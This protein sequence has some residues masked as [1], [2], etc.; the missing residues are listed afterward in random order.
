MAK[1]RQGQDFDSIGHPEIF[2]MSS[3]E[4][5]GRVEEHKKNKRGTREI[6]NRGT[7]DE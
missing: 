3:G 7:K 5:R 1:E 4:G 2:S 6:D